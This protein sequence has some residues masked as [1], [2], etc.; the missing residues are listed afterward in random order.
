MKFAACLPIAL[1][2]A[3][4]HL[5]AAEKPN[6]IVILTDDMGYSDLGCYG[7]EI[8]TPHLDALAAEGL[9]FTNFYNSS[10]CCPTRASLLTGLY[11]HQ[12]GVGAMTADE[13]KPGYR[14]KLNRNCV[15]I[16]EALRPAG[17][18]TLVA[19][20]WHVG[21]G[22]G[23]YPT[24]RGFDR[25]W[26]SPGGGGF[27]FKDSMLSKKREIFS[28]DNKIDPPDDLYVTDDFTDQA[29]GFIDE[30][31]TETKKPFFL[32]LAHIAPHWPLQAKPEDIAKYKGRFDKGWDA[33]RE[34]RFTKQKRMGIVPENAALSA[35]DPEAKSWGETPEAERRDL[36]HRME[37]YAAQI[38]SIDQNTGKLV[39]RLKALGQFENTLI[40]FLS[41]NGCSAEGGAGG[42]SNGEKGAPIGTG[43]SHASAGLEWA[44]ASDTP[45]RKF[46]MH[47]HEGGIATPLIAHWPAGIAARGELRHAACHVIDI[48]PTVIEISGASYPE[49]VSGE[50]INPMEGISLT[51]VFR[52]DDPGQER[53]LFWEHLGKKAVRRGDW[54]A[55]GSRKAPWELYDLRSDPTENKNLA[56]KD[57][58]RT[59]E[60]KALWQAWAERCNVTR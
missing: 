33:E 9:R 54:K 37:I 51:P 22:K 58:E 59:E 3:V 13:G 31:V 55:V 21:E 41:D 39:A 26:G 38:D 56:A 16:A 4:A 19:G 40:L 25:F 27:Y 50:P 32:Y 34:A 29:I 47:T 35:R 17:Y 46:K 11:S 42:F 36:A 43:L 15:T 44:N 57:A 5:A 1:L 23:H 30:A 18:T 49:T 45:F 60:L 12:A 10:R 52:S 28:N 14:G 53:E 48:M 2:I 20:K 24:D 8:E 7:S 6:I